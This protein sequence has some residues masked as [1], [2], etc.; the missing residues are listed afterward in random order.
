MSK[1]IVIGSGLSA[2]ASIKTLVEKGYKPL[3]L[4][5]GEKLDNPIATKTIVGSE[6]YILDTNALVACFS[7]NI[8]MQVVDA[9][10]KMQ[11]IRAV[12]RDA[13][14]KDDKDLINTVESRFKQLAPNTKVHVI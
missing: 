4:D 7:K 11:P 12:F 9:I 10:A 14:F 5:F 8:D 1:I 3:V 6:V 13:C 2:I